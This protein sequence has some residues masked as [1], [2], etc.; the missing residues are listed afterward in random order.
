MC[1]KNHMPVTQLK[2]YAEILKLIKVA[3]AKFTLN[4]Q[5]ALAKEKLSGAYGV[6]FSK[7]LQRCLIDKGYALRVST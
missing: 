5:R 2:L 1:Q 6:T 3:A 4:D 7:P